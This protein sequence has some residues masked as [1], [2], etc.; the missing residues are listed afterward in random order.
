VNLNMTADE[1]VV[2]QLR[3]WWFCQVNE[4]SDID[5]QRRTWLDTTNTNPHWSYVEFIESY[6]HEDQL[7]YALKHG[8]LTPHEFAI[9]RELGRLL[10]AH[11]PPG[12]NY[13]DHAAVLAD[14]AWQAVVSAAE[15]AQRR[16]L[17]M[18]TDQR[19]REMLLGAP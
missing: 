12:G 19:E 14:P 11:T 9:L 4:L 18:T 16:L 17:A 10:D 15:R 2:E 8:W 5:L 1:S 3:C 7:S 6:P 13:Y